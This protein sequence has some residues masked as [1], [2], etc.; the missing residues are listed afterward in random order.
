MDFYLVSKNIEKYRYKTLTISLKEILTLIFT[1]Q[2]IFSLTKL[3]KS[4]YNYYEQIK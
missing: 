1:N 4:N 2:N 3:I